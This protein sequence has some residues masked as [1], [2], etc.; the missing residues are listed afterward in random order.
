MAQ[1]DRPTLQALIDLYITTNGNKEITGAQLNEILTNLNDSLF[2]KIDEPRTEGINTLS[3]NVNSDSTVSL[4][5]TEKEPITEIKFGSIKKNDEY[6][7]YIQ[8]NG[9]GF[10]MKFTEKLFQAFQRLH[11][12]EEFEGTGIG[13]ATV[14]RVIHRH[15]GSIWAEGEP[16]QGAIFYF[17]L[18]VKEFYSAFEKG[19]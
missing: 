16:N 18:N 7:F 2:N 9:V 12:P 4:L 3:F 6:V 15:N 8:D 5:F 17:T 13:L 19:E 11:Q 1:Q 10:D 14:R